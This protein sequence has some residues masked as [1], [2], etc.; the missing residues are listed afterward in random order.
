MKRLI[1]GLASLCAASA[2]LITSSVAGA[3]STPKSWILMANGN[4]LP[5]GLAAK[6]ANAGGTITSTVPEI[7]LAFATSTSGTFGA[8]AAKI[9]GLRSAS[10]NLT[11]QWVD[12]SDSVIADFGYPPAS[13]DNDTL[14][15]LQWGQTAVDSVGAWNAGYRGAGATI[16][17]LDT[18]FNLGHFDLAPNIIGA[19]SMTSDPPGWISAP[20]GF[21]HGTHVAGIAAAPDN[22]FGTI[23]TA[24]DAG[25]LLVRVLNDAGN[26]TFEDVIEG[27]V[28]AANADADVINMSLGGY[29]IKSG[30]PT[31]G[32]TAK[33]A[34]EEKNAIGRA[35]TY[36]YQQGTTVI[37]SA[38]NGAVD[39]DHT[40]NLIHLP[41]DAPHVISISA[42]A[43]T[44][45]AMAPL[46]TPLDDPASYTN[47]G[48]SAIDFAAPG[49]DTGGSPAPCFIPSLPAIVR[50]C[51]VFDFVFSPGTG[52]SPTGFFW[53]AGTSMA[54]PHASGVAAIIVG[55]NGGS[56]N[57]AQV[58]AKMAQSAD[59]LGKPGND[60]FYGAGRVNAA[61]AV[62][63]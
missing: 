18:G 44:N 35:T 12:P 26:G 27:I 19:A 17:I 29:L 5:S 37:A 1:V 38:G 58:E 32:Y 48:Q 34:A 59:D 16:A 9:S 55:A 41:S 51:F 31:E 40:A 6:V 10:P 61:N 3:T 56:M 49:G 54:A 63:P 39:M 43:P 13:G 46:T 15:D 36:A 28:Y 20:L 4:S 33:D 23:G 60:D 11:I 24:P 50:P 22:G 47:F 25:L 21:S 42:T 45:W 62:A 14:F 53:A 52:G 7:G 2:V 30:D 57:P 8:D